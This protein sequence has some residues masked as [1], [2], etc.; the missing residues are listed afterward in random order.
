MIRYVE[1]RNTLEPRICNG[2]QGR[3]FSN[4][5]IAATEWLAQ[6]LQSVQ[7]SIGI[8]RIGTFVAVVTETLEHKSISESSEV[9]TKLTANSCIAL[10]SSKNAVSSSFSRIALWSV[11]RL[12]PRFFAGG[13]CLVGLQ[14]CRENW[15]LNVECS[16]FARS[17]ASGL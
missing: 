14:P 17:C 5:P 12:I 11:I 7:S 2:C 15:T 8:A 16:M 9:M 4:E 13:L 1:M 6:G 3:A 10:C